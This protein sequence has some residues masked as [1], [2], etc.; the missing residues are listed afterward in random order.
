[1]KSFDVDGMVFEVGQSADENEALV[2]SRSA[3]KD[4][5][6]HLEHFP[7]PHGVLHCKDA[8]VHTDV[9]VRCAEIVKSRSKHKAAARVSVS[10]LEVQYL[11]R[12]PSKTGS[13]TLLRQPRAL[14][15]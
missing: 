7:S 10:I 5:W 9:L 1:M 14:V 15:V 11:R 8:E 4:L 2:F 6:F 12:D 3:P 13:V